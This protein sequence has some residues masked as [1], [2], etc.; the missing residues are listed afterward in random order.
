M[1]DLTV[2]GVSVASTLALATIAIFTHFHRQGR[3]NKIDSGNLIMKLLVPWRTDTNFIKCLEFISDPSAVIKKNDQLVLSLLDQFEDIAI[4]WNDDTLSDNHIKEFFGTNLVNIR[5]NT[6][7]LNFIK[8]KNNEKPK[9]YYVNLL[10]L[11][12]KSKKWN[13]D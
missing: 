8:E 1:F 2:V 10:K 4:F 13:I 9:Y 7:I 5:K 11:L 12:E 3:Q 6:S